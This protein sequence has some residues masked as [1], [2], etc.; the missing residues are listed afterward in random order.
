MLLRRYPLATIGSI[1][2]GVNRLFDEAFGAVDSCLAQRSGAFP[3]IDIWEDGDGL[4]FEADVPGLAEGDIDIHIVGNELTI[5]GGRETETQ[6]EGPNY[7]RR[8]RRAGAFERV[9]TLPFDVDSDKVEA[10][11]KDGILTIKLPK[12]E[13]AKPRRITVTTE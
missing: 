4:H 8:E 12:A 9:F 6:D 13:S 10:A 3:A 1:P 11:L 5:K 2:R 7:H